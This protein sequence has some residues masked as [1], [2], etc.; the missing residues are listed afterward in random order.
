[1]TGS[2]SPVRVRAYESSDAEE[3][4]RIFRDA[5]TI[6]ASADYTPEQVAAW[7]NTR[8][9]SRDE[10]DRSMRARN[11][12][13]ALVGEHLAGF[14]DV[15]AGGYIDM[16]FVSPEFA[17]RGVARELARFLE[18]RARETSA[19][20]LSANV[21]ITARPFFESVGFHVVAE[22]H[23]VAGGVVMTNYRMVKELEGAPRRSPPPVR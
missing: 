13:V 16:M 2:S 18:A 22:Q 11:S 7:A 21:S 20:Q 6:T 15:D 8:G 17:R 19:R 23:P 3:T 9:R 14:S 5:I 10:W 1:M 12:C 4:M